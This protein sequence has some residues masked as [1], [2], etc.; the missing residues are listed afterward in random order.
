[1]ESTVPSISGQPYVARHYEITP[2]TDQ[3]NA[4]ARITLYFSQQEFDAYNNDPGSLTNLPT[5]GADA[6]GKANLVIRKYD[7]VSS[8]ASGLPDTYAGTPTDIDPVDTDIVWNATAGRWEVSFDVTGFSGF[9]VQTTLTSLPVSLVE[10]TVKKQ[11]VQAELS[12]QTA[13]ESKNKG[14]FVQRS[15]DGLI[16]TS[17]GFVPAQNGGYSQVPQS[18]QFS[19]R[20][21]S[22]GRNLYR[23]QQVDL[24][25]QFSYSQ[26]REL[27]FSGQNGLLWYPNPVSTNLTI[28]A[29]V[30]I[31]H[32]VS[33]SLSDVHGRII[34]T[35]KM[36]E[37]RGLQQ[38]NVS[39]LKPGYYQIM[40]VDEKGSRFLQR[41]L[42]R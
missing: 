18:Y 40:L 22:K 41:I 5:S 24:D 31:L 11:G 4:T 15:N 27:T 10:F 33:I 3:P 23:L 19:D 35:W 8:D 38:L 1:V 37:V 21:P 7:G 30:D 29:G 28:D 25:G 16:F 20:T 12:W 32:Q 9:I 26:I 17:I 2:A 13:V 6:V 34:R 14:F 42:K 36:E 39:D